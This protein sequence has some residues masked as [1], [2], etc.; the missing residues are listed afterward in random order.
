M[1]KIIGDHQHEFWQNKLRSSGL[2]HHIVLW[3]DTN[4]SEVHAASIFR[5]KGTLTNR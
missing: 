1:N 3:W 2:W 5:V 4:I